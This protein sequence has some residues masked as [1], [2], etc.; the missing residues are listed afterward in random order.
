MRVTLAS[1]IAIAI[2]LGTPSVAD[3]AAVLGLTTVI[4]GDTIEIGGQRIRLKGIDAPE[5]SQTC[6]RDGQKWACGKA[7][8]DQVR[9]MIGD[10]SLSCV[11]HETD[12]FGRLVAICRIGEVDLNRAIVAAGW[13]TA[14]RRYSEAYVPDEV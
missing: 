2:S 12:T 8:A 11:G 9:S 14:F 3:A 7:A 10:A 1:A 4:D 5:L 6:D 13:A